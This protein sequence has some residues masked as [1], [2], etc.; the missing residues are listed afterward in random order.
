MEERYPDTVEVTSSSLVVPTI[1][2]KVYREICKPFFMGE[3]L[4]LDFLI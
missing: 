1:K 4:A 2:K 3:H